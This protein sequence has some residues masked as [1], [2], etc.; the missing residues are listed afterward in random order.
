MQILEI[1]YAICKETHQQEINMD[2]FFCW[3]KKLFLFDIS[4]MCLLCDTEKGRI[5][6]GSMSG[7]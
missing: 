6:Y 2:L 4:Y 1:S 3:Q 5:V 7:A